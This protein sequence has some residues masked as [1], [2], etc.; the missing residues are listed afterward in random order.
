M[1]KDCSIYK[2]GLQLKKT[3]SQRHVGYI[4]HISGGVADTDFFFVRDLDVVFPTKGSGFSCSS[5]SSVISLFTHFI[6]TQIIHMGKPAQH[7][8]DNKTMVGPSLLSATTSI[9][10][11]PSNPRRHTQSPIQ[12]HPRCFLYFRRCEILNQLPATKALT[13]TQ[14]SKPS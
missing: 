13:V 7:A 4:C 11:V 1:K 12:P 2:R 6:P 8:K 5:V 14:L 9:E 3:L 10:D